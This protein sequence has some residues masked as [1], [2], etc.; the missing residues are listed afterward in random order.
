MYPLVENT[1]MTY[2]NDPL[3]N[4][5]FVVGPKELTSNDIDAVRKAAS[6]HEIDPGLV[7]DIHPRDAFARAT[8]ALLKAGLIKKGNRGVFR[9]RL[10][11]GEDGVIAYQ[12]SARQVTDFAKYPPQ[13]M[14]TF[15]K[16]SETI[17]VRPL[18][19]ADAA[20]QASVHAEVMELY[21]K[22]GYTY[23]AQHLGTL[24]DRI[25]ASVTR[26][27]P[28]RRSVFFIGVQHESL[29]RKVRA[30]LGEL[31]ITFYIWTIGAG[32]E[33]TRGDIVLAIVDDIKKNVESLTEEIAKLKK[34]GKLTKRMAKKRFKDKFAE[35]AQYRSILKGLHTSTGEIM[36][37]AG[38]AGT[39]L[40]LMAKGPDAVIEAINSGK[41]ASELAV[42]L[43]DFQE[44]KG[45]ALIVA[46]SK[47]GVPELVCKD[48]D[49]EAPLV[50]L[51]AHAPQL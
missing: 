20:Q 48:A 8:R 30:F 25:F 36:K 33:E 26:K 10:S 32:E 29:V 3:D 4:V 43:A 16:D 37:K 41:V 28:V 34:E 6:K 19:E 51:P 42:T 46:A 2:S 31:G 13:Y 7:R 9:D 27:I 5:G 45:G 23:T 39:T 17:S 38:K 44:E 35:L 24:V 47:L 50:E 14:I 15:R 18:G 40:T 21:K 1:I 12:Y 11:E 49:A 22:A